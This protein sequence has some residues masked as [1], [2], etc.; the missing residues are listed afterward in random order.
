MT[1]GFASE[2]P[3]QEAASTEWAL[4][5][6]F[7]IH[8]L[9]SMASAKVVEGSHARNGFAWPWGTHATVTEGPSLPELREGSR[10]GCVAVSQ[11]SC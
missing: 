4:S 9:T 3:G 6:L 8:C 10:R 7:R 2:L 5:I 1:S 11:R